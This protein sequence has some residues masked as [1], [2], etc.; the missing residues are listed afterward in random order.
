MAGVRPPC[1]LSGYD[2][3]PI[4]FYAGCRSAQ[5][6]GHDARTDP[7]ALVLAARRTPFAVLSAPGARPP[8]YA[9]TWPMTQVGVLHAYLAPAAL[10][11]TLTLRPA[12]G[13]R[14][15]A[16]GTAG[17]ARATDRSKRRSHV[18]AGGDAGLRSSHWLNVRRAGRTT[19]LPCIVVPTSSTRSVIGVPWSGA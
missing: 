4:A 10:L 6:T 9:R 17:P 18:P 15:D 13:M 19:T 14:A 12:R 7:A 11:G 1:L 2:A 5:A 8:T 3:V 16:L